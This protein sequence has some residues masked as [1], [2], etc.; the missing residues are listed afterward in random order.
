M[1]VALFWGKIRNL[2]I[3]LQ[4]EVSVFQSDYFS[5]VVIFSPVLVPSSVCAYLRSFILKHSGQLYD[6]TVPELFRFSSARL[7]A[8]ELL[9]PN[10]GSLA[11][12]GG[13]EKER[14]RPYLYLPNIVSRA[15]LLL[16][17]KTFVLYSV[18]RPFRCTVVGNLDSFFRL[19]SFK[20]TEHIQYES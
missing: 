6:L 3:P 17:D 19:M 11:F 16:P 2:N 9:F 8:V 12:C 7:E 20:R 18:K 15:K 14:L 10:G 13:V 1:E 4:E 5:S